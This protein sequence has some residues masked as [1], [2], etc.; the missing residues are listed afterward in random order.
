MENIWNDMGKTST[1]ILEIGF[2][3]QWVS[4]A[5]MKQHR[6]LS[7]IGDW[8]ANVDGWAGALPNMRLSK[9]GGSRTSRGFWLLDVVGWCR[10]SCSCSHLSNGQDFAMMVV[11]SGFSYQAFAI[12]HYQPLA[13]ILNNYIPCSLGRVRSFY[14]YCY[15]LFAPSMMFL[16]IGSMS[17]GAT[18][19]MCVSVTIHSRKGVL[20]VA[21]AMPVASEISSPINGPQQRTVHLD[22]PKMRF[23]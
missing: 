2:I 7:N 12:C 20:P 19:S 5:N 8:A 1:T 18:K 15:T 21:P 3:F 22:L 23:C 11:V 14:N 10:G 9:A 16:L 6:R 4:I 17:N 13:G